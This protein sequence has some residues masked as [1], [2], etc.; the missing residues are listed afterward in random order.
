[1]YDV[2]Y[3]YAKGIDK[4][5]NN[6]CKSIAI[7]EKNQLS[8]CVKT[9]LVPNM[10][11]IENDGTIKIKLDENGDVYARWRIYQNQNGNPV[12]V[13][14]YDETK[15]PKLQIF[16]EQINWSVF[17]HFSTQA[18]N[19]DG[20]NIITPESVCSKPCKAK[21]YLLQQELQC[22]WICRKC[23]VNE[24]IVNGTGC[25]ACPFGQ[26][27]DEETA[28][29]CTIIETTYQK[30]SS[31]ITLLLTG[32]TI[33]GLLFTLYTTI[34]YILKR[35]EN[36]IK[37]TTR[38]L[39]SIILAGILIAYITALFYFFKP[40][41]W[42]CVINRHGFNLSIILIYSPLFVKTNRIYRIFQAGQKGIQKPKY[43][44][45]ITQIIIS[46][47]LILIGVRFLFESSLALVGICLFIISKWVSFYDELVVI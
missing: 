7:R 23:L 36:I 42:F 15:D 24:Y 35:H 45:T 14:T 39:C 4:A 1:M 22:C 29:Y 40:T 34:F 43:I 33:V 13:A 2:A 41:Y 8:S 25:E 9:N 10:K 5:L 30:W 38:E 44:G 12:L 26:W 28:T 19:I 11:F 21:E 31:W 46:A 17:S 32:I 27:P 18:L 6:E 16:T 47:L 3:L 20:Q 37:A